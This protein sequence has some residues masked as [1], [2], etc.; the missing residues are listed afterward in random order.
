[1]QVQQQQI[2]SCPV[3]GLRG[4][5]APPVILW[6]DHV[7]VSHLLMS[8]LSTESRQIA[9]IARAD[10]NRLTVNSDKDRNA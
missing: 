2:K 4:Y 7:R 5:S 8:F 3:Y 10:A 9:D 1:M 6:P